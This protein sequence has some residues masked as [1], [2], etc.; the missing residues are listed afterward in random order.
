MCIFVFLTA[1]HPLRRCDNRGS[2][3]VAFCANLLLRYR[4]APGSVGLDVLPLRLTLTARFGLILLFVAALPAAGQDEA[5]L[6]DNLE[7]LSTISPRSNDDFNYNDIWGYVHNGR[8][9]AIV[10]AFD[11]TYFV[12]VTDPRNPEVVDFVGGARSVWRDIKTYGDYAYITHDAN[13]NGF[14]KPGIQI[15]D[16]SNLPNNVMLVN[17]FSEQMPSGVAHNLYIDGHHAWVAGARENDQALVLDLADPRNPVVAAAYSDPYWHDIVVNNGMVFGS[18]LDKGIHLMDGTDPADL[19]EI[20]LT[21]YPGNFT[22]NMWPTADNLFLV[23]T[24]ER[25]GAPLRFWDISNPLEPEQV[26]SYSV[27]GQAVA[28]NAHVLGEYAYVSYYWD[29]LKI[30]DISRREAPVE[31]AHYDTY[32]DD[33]FGRG[34]GFDGAWGVYPN[35]PSGNILVSD[36]KYGLFVLRHNRETAAYLRGVIRD[37]RDNSPIPDAEVKVLDIPIYGGTSVKTSDVEGRYVI[38]NKAGVH[39]MRYFKYGFEPLVVNDVEFTSDV[40]QTRDVTLVK[41]PT[42]PVNIQVRDRYGDPVRGVKVHIESNVFDFSFDAESDQRGDIMRT[43]LFDNY[44]ISVNQWGFLPRQMRFDISKQEEVNSIEFIVERG[45]YEPFWPAEGWQTY[46]EADSADTWTLVTAEKQEFDRVL[47]KVDFLDR[48]N[49]VYIFARALRGSAPLTSPTFNSG[50]INNPVLSF[51]RWYNAPEYDNNPAADDSLIVWISNDDG[52]TWTVAKA[53]T[54]VQDAEWQLVKMRLDQSI[55]PTATMKLRF[56]L[57][58][59][60]RENRPTIR[61]RRPVYAALDELIIVS[62]EVISAVGQHDIKAAAPPLFN[63]F[64]NPAAERIV[65]E[66]SSAT[67]PG[68]NILTVSDV[69]GRVVLREQL[70][71]AA[72]TLHEIDLRQISPGLYFVEFGRPGEPA[73]TRILIVDR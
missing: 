19:R 13:E 21:G 31:V 50:N 54:N 58:E 41:I 24:D 48:A 53:F 67:A 43:L 51:R 63:M 70:S 69:A 20:S 37:G 40:D 44:T 65:I 66:L 35:L 25:N 10:G 71:A 12:D 27:P 17:T 2:K 60:D 68:A 1:A 36:M 26:A 6:S 64:P 59:G 28:H 55:Q 62:E 7:L 46:D 9:F 49:G 45:Y 34:R 56:E 8:E 47:P 3:L 39:R 72:G 42:G 23:V 32:P 73:Q 18:A 14:D 38:G 5:D 30:F 57:V 22:H 52:E 29:G 15:V 11:G 33:E 16:L 61:V 4:S